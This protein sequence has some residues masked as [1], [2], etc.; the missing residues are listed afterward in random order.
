MQGT[1]EAWA[2]WKPGEFNC[3]RKREELLSEEQQE[4]EAER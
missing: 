4:R 3:A 2:G 1:V